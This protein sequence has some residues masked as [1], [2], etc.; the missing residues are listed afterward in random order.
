M[1]QYERYLLAQLCVTL[2]EARRGRTQQPLRKK[3][4]N[5]INYQTDRTISSTE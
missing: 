3:T 4:A 5:A 1:I 2:L